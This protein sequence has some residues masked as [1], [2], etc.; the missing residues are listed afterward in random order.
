M[1]SSG[2]VVD[3]FGSSGGRRRRISIIIVV[4]QTVE[5]IVFS[6][7]MFVT[8]RRNSFVSIQN[9]RVADGLIWIDK[10]EKFLTLNK[11][12]ISIPI[13]RRRMSSIV[14]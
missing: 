6:E 4:V 14:R 12:E 11:L 7:K 9:G 2:D 10:I 1:V 13:R 8:R 5:G 3:D